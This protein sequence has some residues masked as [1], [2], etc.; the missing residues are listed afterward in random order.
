[1]G[2]GPHQAGGNQAA[3]PHGAGNVAMAA[4]HLDTALAAAVNTA[5]FQAHQVC[6]HRTL[7]SAIQDA[8]HIMDQA[9]TS[10]EPNLSLTS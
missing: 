10:S 1:M 6:M 3:N 8:K 5:A 7:N 2:H 9:F 4:H